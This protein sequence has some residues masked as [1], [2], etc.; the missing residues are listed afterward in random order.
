MRDSGRGHRRPGRFVVPSPRH[1]GKE[2]HA[3]S[4]KSVSTDSLAMDTGPKEHAGRKLRMAIVGC[5]GIAQVH[6]GA[7]KDFPDV[8]IVAGV[9]TDPARLKVME[10]K[11]G[12]KQ[13]FA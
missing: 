10:E 8:E 6:L 4:E 5:G 2:H 11:W 12:V 13:N 7:L 3:M 1:S 9:D